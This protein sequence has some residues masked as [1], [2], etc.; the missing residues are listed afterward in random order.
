MEQ[1]DKFTSHD[2]FLAGGR[3]RPS[4]HRA[5]GG[6]HTRVRLQGGH[7]GAGEQ[8]AAA[9][10]S[11]TTSSA[12]VHSKLEKKE[13]DTHKHRV[14]KQRN[15]EPTAPRALNRDLAEE[16]DRAAEDAA[17]AMDEERAPDQEEELLTEAQKAA[18]GRMA[19]TSA[20]QESGDFWS[21]LGFMLDATMDTLRGQFATA[22]NDVE[23]RLNDKIGSESVK[24]EAMD[25][26]LDEVA[27]RVD[28]LERADTAPIGE[29]AA[30]PPRRTDGWVQNSVIV[31]GFSESW[32]D[33]Q[34][35]AYTATVMRKAQINSEQHLV[36][37]APPCSSIVKARCANTLRRPDPLPAHARAREEKRMRRRKKCGRRLS[38]RPRRD[39]VDTYFA[40]QRAI[41]RGCWSRAT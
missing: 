11:T 8:S 2:E 36:P 7:A 39:I 1:Y 20:P 13:A 12:G 15:S 27:L 3:W 28:K 14:L 4:L 26:A 5:E 10:S 35:V 33:T 29:P 22:L 23:S 34:K 16:L 25:T 9:S 32:T 21:K 6:P 18:Q 37:F 30:A 19:S 40:A 31:G 41:S 24:K 38:A 17:A